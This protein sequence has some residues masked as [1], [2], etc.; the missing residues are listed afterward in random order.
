LFLRILDAVADRHSGLHEL[1]MLLDT[2]SPSNRVVYIYAGLALKNAQVADSPNLRRT[3][4][5]EIGEKFAQQCTRYRR[6]NVR[7][8]LR[9]YLRNAT[10]RRAREAVLV[11]GLIVQDG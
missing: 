11:G 3:L 9:R 1:C 6:R 5:D 2:E 10:A 8:Q 7:D 4:P